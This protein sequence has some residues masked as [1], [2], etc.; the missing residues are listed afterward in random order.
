MNVVNFIGGFMI[1]LLVSVLLTNPA[2]T[3][4]NSVGLVLCLIVCV[5]IVGIAN[6]ID[7]ADTKSKR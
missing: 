7:Y 2:T 6:I 5:I 4:E 3:D 1:G